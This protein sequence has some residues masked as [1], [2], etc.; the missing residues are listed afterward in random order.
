MTTAKRRAA[1]KRRIKLAQRA[2]R[3]S[4]PAPP[5]R[6]GAVHDHRRAWRED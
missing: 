1:A 6:S 4:V 2:R 3:K 5:K